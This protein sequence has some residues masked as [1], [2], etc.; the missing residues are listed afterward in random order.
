MRFGVTV[1]TTNNICP[2]KAKPALLLPGQDA[3]PGPP[4]KNLANGLITHAISASRLHSEI[5]VY[6]INPNPR[7]N[8]LLW[9]LKEMTLVVL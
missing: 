9:E 6:K 1:W 2:S 8:I 7:K 5:F 4:R 3:L